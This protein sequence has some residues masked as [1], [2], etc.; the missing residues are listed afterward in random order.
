MEPPALGAM[1]W[2]QEQGQDGVQGPP[3]LSLLWHR[4]GARAFADVLRGML[5]PAE[6]SVLCI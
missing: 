5:G 3:P 2:S 6:L 1:G 4:Y